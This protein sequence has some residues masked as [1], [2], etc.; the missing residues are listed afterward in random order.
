MIDPLAWRPSDPV[1]IA[2]GVVTGLATACGG[3]IT[4]RFHSRLAL[5]RNFSS[6]AVLGVAL[7]DLL[8]EALDLGTGAHSP[9]ALT[10]CVALGFAVY[11][12]AHAWS[13]ARPASA[14]GSARD[15]G[16]ASLTLHSLSDGLG[17]GLAF[18]VSAAVGVVV[19]VAV[20]AHDVVDGANTVTLSL[21]G[22]GSTRRARGWLI[23]DALAPL[24]GI[25]ASRFVVIPKAS[26]A[27]LLAVFAG[28]FL[29]IGTSHTA[30]EGPDAPPR[31]ATAAT[32]LLG[33][34]FIFVIVRLAG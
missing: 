7:F 26:L 14:G 31:L 6:G 5:L 17:I 13:G 4:L 30:A 29:H 25:A 10:A 12:L 24:A 32:L 34:A 21:V 22:G 27:V 11:A 2:I 20:L 19:A 28:F 18:Q 23:A 3:L 16:P 15:L 9:T 33:M 1:L 8:P